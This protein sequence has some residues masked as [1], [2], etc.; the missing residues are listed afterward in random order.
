M[1]FGTVAQ[2]YTPIDLNCIQFAVT[3]EIGVTGERLVRPGD[4]ADRVCAGLRIAIIEQALPPGTRLAEDRLAAQH[5]VSRTVVRAA[6]DRLVGEGL[7]ERAN[8]RSAR[9]ATIGLEDAA[10]LLQVRQGLEA[11]VVERLAGRL[12]AAGERQLRTHVKREEHASSLNRPEAIRLAGEFHVLLAELTG[13][14][15]L[16]RFVTDVVSRS[17]LILTGHAR[18]HSS[19]CAVREHEALIGWLRTG[20]RGAAQAGMRDHLSGVVSRAHLGKQD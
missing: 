16:L 14:A 1:P 18:P 15:A 19:S 20:N 5:Q 7:V 11:M 13:S 9:V 4:S 17:S 3:G 8:N 12:S 2:S 6:L 10:D